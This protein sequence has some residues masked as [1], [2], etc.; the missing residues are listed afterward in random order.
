MSPR[1]SQV[2]TFASPGER[3]T[4]TVNTD[5]RG[6]WYPTSGRQ[7]PSMSGQD[8]VAR[9][10]AV[11][12]TRAPRSTRIRSRFG[13]WILAAAMIALVSAVS[14]A[15]LLWPQYFPRGSIMPV[16]VLAGLLLPWR[17]LILVYAVVAAW[18]A[19]VLDLIQSRST[20]GAVLVLALVMVLML[21]M[22]RSRALVGVQA[23]GSDRMLVDLRDRLRL[24]GEMPRLPAG[25][26]AESAI[27]PAHGD[28]FSGDF[29]VTARSGDGGTFEIVV[30]DVS[31]KGLRAGTRSLLLSGAFSGLL[32]STDEEGFLPAANSYLLRQQWSEGFATAVHVRICTRTGAFTAAS[33]G[34]PP[35]VKYAAGSGRWSVLGGRAGPLLG[36][37]PEASFPRLSGVLE[38]GD[39]LLLYT[40]GVIESRNRHLADG[41]DRMLGTAERSVKSGFSGMATKICHAARSGENDDRAVVVVWRD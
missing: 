36:V 4:D 5:D 3:P 10:R 6:Q 38:R 14:L 32:G 24:M 17:A 35:A 25:W 26:H 16:V 33:A 27:E 29:M 23:L 40:D 12:V 1:S 18:A 30:V 39:A 28:A 15:V 7:G 31:G 8:S 34:H 22:S 13:S 11:E 37:M 19:V 2:D 9:A 41:I 20:P 21:W